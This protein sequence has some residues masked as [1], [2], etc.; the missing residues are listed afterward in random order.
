MVAKSTT[1]AVM[2][3]EKSTYFYT[4]NQGLCYQ[5]FISFVAYEL[6]LQAVVL[7]YIGWN[8][9]LGTNTLA[10]TYLYYLV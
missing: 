5:H 6:A 7:H 1:Q 4:K 2:V 8:G 10:W 9:L 3:V